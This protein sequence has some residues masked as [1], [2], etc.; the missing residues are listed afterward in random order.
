MKIDRKW[1]ALRAHDVFGG[2]A[3]GD[4]TPRDRGDAVAGAYGALAGLHGCVPEA[5]G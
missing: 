1:S 4:S 5:G 3:S 2:A